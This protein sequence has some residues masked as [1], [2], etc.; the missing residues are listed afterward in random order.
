MLQSNDR[1]NFQSA[2]NSYLVKLR[3]I[4]SRLSNQLWQVAETQ[5]CRPLILSLCPIRDVS[6]TQPQP[7]PIPCLL[8]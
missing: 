8:F 1:E 3:I 5:H 2:G 6:F 7:S 4:F